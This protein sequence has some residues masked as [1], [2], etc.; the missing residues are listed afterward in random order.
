M[1]GTSRREPGGDTS[2]E[3]DVLASASVRRVQAAL[4][5]LGGGHRVVELTESARTATDA[6][7][8]LGCRVDQIVKS[9]VFRGRRTERAILVAASGAN[10]V[11]EVKVGE[12]LAEPIAK[13]D[14]AFVR[15][16]TGFAIGGV[17]PVGH[18]EPVP[19]LIDED[20]M[21][22]EEIWA[23]AGHPS[24]IFR[25]TPADLVRMTSGRVVVIRV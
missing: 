19:T 14:A 23:A 7:R 8:A 12:L 11:D 13:A 6:A 24:S 10:R 21:K 1:S 2:G 15:A 5:A 22:W 3:R 25:L 4:D 20:L 17:A 9:L 18:A 16:R